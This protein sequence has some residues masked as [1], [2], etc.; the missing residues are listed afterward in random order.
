MKNYFKENDFSKIQTGNMVRIFVKKADEPVSGNV[1]ENNFNQSYIRINNKS[2]D[3]MIRYEQ[4]AVAE[5]ELIEFN[6]F[7]YNKEREGLGLPKIGI[8]PVS[9]EEIENLNNFCG[10]INHEGCE[11]FDLGKYNEAIEK[12][13]LVL[14]VN[15]K[16]MPTLYNMGLALF[17]LSKFQEAKEM[18][19]R[20][21]EIDP[22]YINALSN[23]LIISGNLDR[24]QDVLD[25]SDK[26][27]EIDQKNL[28][29]L[30][31]KGFAMFKL[32]KN[33]EALELFDEALKI[34]PEYLLAI[35]NKKLILSKLDI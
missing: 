35:N 8:T 21:L 26:I 6:I 25:I 31:A 16:Y 22:K 12:Y 24:P 11:L 3:V 9:E 15:P 32:G 10:S 5:I 30:N 23:N 27:L 17:N 13:N 20:V 33:K 4:I 7:E 1:V 18:F 34:D 29:A 28:R 2:S 19:D 14:E